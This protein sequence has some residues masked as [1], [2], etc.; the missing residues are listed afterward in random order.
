M[1]PILDATAGNRMMWK[2]KNPPHVVFM[3]KEIRLR[4]PP[5]IFGIWEKLPFRD[6]VF[7]CIIFD[8]P[9]YR[10]FGK[11]SIHKDPK[12]ES[13][14]GEYLNK[15]HFM[16]S[17]VYSSKEFSRVAERLCLKWGESYW[18]YFEKTTGRYRKRNE[19]PT[20][21]KILGALYSWREVFRVERKSQYGDSN[22]KLYWVTMVNKL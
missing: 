4:I 15:R 9:H 17:L 18:S 20:L 10:V 12:G 6:D 14:L 7:S 5:H 11:K 3:D 21:W 8:P 22:Q 13:W 1:K 19:N 2:N 16:R